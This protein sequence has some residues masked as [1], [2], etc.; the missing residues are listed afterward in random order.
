[1]N[2]DNHSKPTGKPKVTV[3]RILPVS[4]GEAKPAA[5]LSR[6]GCYAP[7]AHMIGKRVVAQRKSGVRVHGILEDLNNPDGLIVF[8]DATIYG[9]NHTQYVGSIYMFYQK[10]T[11]DFVHFHLEQVGGASEAS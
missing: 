7:I 11:G 2:N 5:N 8:S 3:R 6:L 9:T 1:M 10:N 4:A